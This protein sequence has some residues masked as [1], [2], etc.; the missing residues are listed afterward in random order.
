MDKR[1]FLK[2]SSAFT[3]AS[4]I[5]PLKNFAQQPRLKNWAGN[6]EYGTSDVSYP[7]STE[8]VQELVKKFEKVKALGTRHCFNDIADSKHHLLSTKELNKIVSI[9]ELNKTVTIEGGMNYGQ[10]CPLLEAK[11]FALHNLAS[12]PHISVAGACTTATHGS[13]VANGNL[14][15][16]VLELELVT[17]DGS[18]VQFSKFKDKEKFYGAAVGLGALGVITKMKL[19]VLPTYPVRQFVF[20]R[21]PLQQLKDHFEEVI[22]AG[23]S[24]SLFT[25]WSKESV[26]E[27]WIKDIIPGKRRSKSEGFFGATPATKNLHPI[28]E[29][30]A[31]NCTAQLG[32]P[33]T[34][35]ER[36]PH[37]KMGFTPSSGKELQ[38][39]Y[40]VPRK[41]GLD[42]FLAIQKMGKE[43]TP[44]LFI[45]EIRTIAADQFWMSPCYKQDCVAIHFTWKQDWPAVSKLLPKIEKELSPYNVKPHWG[46]LFT[47]PGATL[48]SRYEKMNDFKKLANELDPHGKFRN[49]FLTQNIFS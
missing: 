19:A 14:A 41:N 3:M 23:Y 11:G 25:D 40:F 37:F 21:L 30:S 27:V 4:L 28:A 26:N 46:K 43:I 20:E 29:L 8:E 2:L 32:E 6:L 38:A 44:H 48:A 49:D 7:K 35:Y 12:L 16:A 45:S 13:G 34:W 9:D 31:E 22:S 24:V 17:A 36:L 33:G 42:A 15:T 47:I 10:L 39:E 1:T 18:V 5:S